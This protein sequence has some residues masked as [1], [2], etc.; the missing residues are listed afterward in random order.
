[1]ENITLT[2]N[3]SSV[4]GREGMSILEV[5]KENGI[6]IPTLCYIAEL[7]PTGACRI[8]VVE[9]EGSRALVAACHTPI[10]KG[11]VIQTHSPK[12]LETR[13]VIVELLLAS[14]CGFCMICEKANICDLR[15]IAADLEVGLPR[16]ET[17]K[18]FYQIE[19]VSPYV[20]RD[21]SK[22]VLCWKCIRACREIAKKNVYATA[23]RGFDDKVV[24]DCDQPLNKEVCRDCGICINY[25]PTGAL[26][27]PKKLGEAKK[28]KPLVIS[29]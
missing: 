24:V 23:Y 29:G 22:C 13:K 10:A 26:T 8:C 2:I 17:E 18:R 21:M 6:D 9:V 7:S 20:Q 5:A 19:D 14:H 27:R 11:M 28:G 12:V 1:M 3:G 16:F 15:K 25:C 4:S